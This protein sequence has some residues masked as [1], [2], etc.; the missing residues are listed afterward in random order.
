MGYLVIYRK[1]CLKG[2][3]AKRLKSHERRPEFDRLDGQWALWSIALMVNRLY[4]R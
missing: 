3:Q 1:T 4:G 2:E